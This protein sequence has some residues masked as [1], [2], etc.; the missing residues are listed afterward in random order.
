MNLGYPMTLVVVYQVLHNSN[1]YGIVTV[2]IP[3]DH[4]ELNK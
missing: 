3:F 2:N 4:F 1:Q